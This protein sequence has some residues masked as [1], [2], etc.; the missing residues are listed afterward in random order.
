M[1]NRER[2]RAMCKGHPIDRQ[3]FMFYFGPWQE[4][5]ERWMGEG[6]A[7]DWREV[8]CMDAGIE[9]L[10]INLG[11]SPAFEPLLIEEREKTRVIRDERGVTQIIRT[12]GA[13]IPH[14]ID[15]P[16]K[17]ESDWR[18]LKSRLDPDDSKRFP[19]DFFARAN[20]LN[21]GDKAVQIGS[22]P[23]GLFG[24]LRDMMGVEEL[25]INFIDQ[26]DLIAEMMDYLTDLWL[27]IYEKALKHV[28][29]DII[30]IWEDM[31]GKTGSLIS[32]NMVR[33]FMCPNYRRI[34]EFAKEH[35]IAVVAVDTD[36]N[37]EDLIPPFMEAGINLIMPFEVQA[38]SDV[39]K[40]R[41][42]YPDLTIMGGFDK[43]AL[44]TSED[45]IDAEFARLKPMF[46]KAVRY[47]CMPDHLIPPEVPLNLFRY[48][49][50]RLRAE[51]G[52]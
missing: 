31:S 30:H 7:G 51:I 20:A 46:D 43:R 22:Y 2:I 48:F 45:A 25:L 24:T 44:W 47:I 50:G 39:N 35:D 14:F 6:L 12:D 36:G 3:P 29:V 49:M 4:T 11:Y 9:T 15:Y 23:Y 1:N 18:A 17:S 26:P 33:K 16:V 5:I 19:A 13:S 38:G 21:N 28:K 42:R 10:N 27:I 52:A 32:P 37:C 41:E 34:S 8:F 40:Y